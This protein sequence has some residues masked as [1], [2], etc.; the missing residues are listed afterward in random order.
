M[1]NFS[2]SS[3]NALTA[4]VVLATC[5][6][7]HGQSVQGSAS[8]LSTVEAVGTVESNAVTNTRKS[9]KTDDVRQG[10]AGVALAFGTV[11][12]EPGSGGIGS[13]LTLHGGISLT[14][15][16]HL[17][18]V[19]LAL[20]IGA[21]SPYLDFTGRA[22]A[23]SSPFYQIRTGLERIRNG[24][25]GIFH[26]HYGLDAIAT[27]YDSVGT[28]PGSKRIAAATRGGYDIR[29][30][31]FGFRGTMELGYGRTFQ[32]GADPFNS[33]EIRAEWS[34]FRSF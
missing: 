16:T 3:R 28:T 19:H 21:W 2:P 12:T 9:I 8:L 17:D 32:N 20:G 29:G 14:D 11:A 7:A 5:G 4:F 23:P 13:M 6:V 33:P 22:P 15:S 30:K 10:Y 1:T 24:K 31:H 25:H 18:Y 26:W 27:T 34:F